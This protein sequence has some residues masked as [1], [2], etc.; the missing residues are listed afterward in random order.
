MNVLC[1]YRLLLTNA[2]IQQSS[3]FPAGW[4]EGRGLGLGYACEDVD[5]GWDAVDLTAAQER[6]E[7]VIVDVDHS[8][9]IGCCEPDGGFEPSY[10]TVGMLPVT[11][12]GIFSIAQ[13]VC[14][15][16]IVPSPGLPSVFLYACIE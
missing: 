6:V 11:S 12:I 14:S 7:E 9:L 10:P 5:C 8:L 2:K 16:S 15:G 4:H 3:P 1:K 13:G